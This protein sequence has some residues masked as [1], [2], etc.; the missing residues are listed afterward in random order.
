MS[1]AISN[2]AARRA[3]VLAMLDTLQA[4]YP[5]AFARHRPALAIGISDAIAAANPDLNRADL[6]TAMSLHCASVTYLRSVAYGPRRV[7]LYGQPGEAPT[8][9]AR[10]HAV[11][12]LTAMLARR[13]G[14]LMP[15]PAV[16][17]EVAQPVPAPAPKASGINAAKPRLSLKRNAA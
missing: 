14:K 6:G 5:L 8:D 4:R 10:Q 12:R 15:A 2:K 3:R 7:D 9:D 16:T 1:E 11:Q 13:D 17:P